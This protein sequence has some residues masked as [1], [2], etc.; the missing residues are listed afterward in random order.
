M[1]S[2][3]RHHSRR[4]CVL[5][6]LGAALAAC[7]PQVTPVP[8]DADIDPEPRPVLAQAGAAP[9]PAPRS[10]I[11]EDLPEVSATAPTPTPVPGVVPSAT[12]LTPGAAPGTH[13]PAV[14]GGRSTPV[15]AGPTLPSPLD[16]IRPGTPPN[17]AAATRLTEAARIRLTAGDDAAALDQLE[18][19]IAIDP[20]NAYAYFFLAQLHLRTGSYDQAIAFA[21]RAAGLSVSG[22]PQWT[23]RAWVLQGSA[24]EAA[25]RF[26]DARQAYLRAV[27]AAPDNEAALAGLARTGGTASAP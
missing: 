25:G 13:A 12:P 7:G 20:N 9:E 27:R 17:V 15:A 21:D 6:A 11:E 1:P 16:T 22:G 23:C 2:A 19:A 3:Q 18:R 10:L 5:S 8:L 24:Y 14:A 26:A 4:L